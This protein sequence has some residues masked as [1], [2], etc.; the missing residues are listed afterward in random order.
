MK[1]KFAPERPVSI[2]ALTVITEGVVP[3][4]NSSPLYLIWTFAKRVL[5]SGIRF[6]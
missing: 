2:A 3:A 5:G 4:I 6:S 1:V